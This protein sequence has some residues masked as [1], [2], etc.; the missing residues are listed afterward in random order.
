MALPEAINVFLEDSGIKENGFDAA[1]FAV[2][3]PVFKG[4]SKLLNLPWSVKE[5]DLRF[6][7]RMKEVYLI[8]DFQAIGHGLSCLT[9]NDLYSLQGAKE[10]K[11][12]PLAYIGAGTGLG[13]GYLTRNEDNILSS[14]TAT[15]G[16]HT[17]FAPINETQIEL[18]RVLRS[19]Y[20]RVSNERLLTGSGLVEI[21][22]FVRAHR[23]F[24]EEENPELRHALI[25][26]EDPAE[27]IS[28]F[29]LV[30]KDIIAR[31]ALD[32]FIDIYGA[33][34]GN[35]SLMTLPYSGLYIVG[36]IALK[37]REYIGESGRFMDAFLDKGRMS[38]LLKKIPVNIVTNPDVGL[39][40]AAMYARRMLVKSSK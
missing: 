18:L 26:S 14:A 25:C 27:R 11:N 32:I 34:A 37:N 16:G 6:F 20:Y 1:C 22:Q 29:A 9:G 5:N 19:K 40:G 31:R 4:C 30:E 24:H 33:V 13:V 36:G 17:D 35:I 38:G 12:S 23:V 8:N 3:G 7:L 21:Y 10:V 15:E 28:H 39:I 2:P